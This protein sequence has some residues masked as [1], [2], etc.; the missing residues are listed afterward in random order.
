MIRNVDKARCKNGRTSLE[1]IESRMYNDN[2]I[3]IQSP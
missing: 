3:L 2:Q 1:E